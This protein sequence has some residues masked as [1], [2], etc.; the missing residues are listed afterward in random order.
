MIRDQNLESIDVI[1]A[2]IRDSLDA[3]HDKT[4]IN[5]DIL[6][7]TDIVSEQQN[8]IADAILHDHDTKLVFN[9]I[10]AFTNHLEQLKSKNYSLSEAEIQ[11]LF[12][13]ALRP[14]LKSWLNNNISRIVREILEQEIKRVIDRMINQNQ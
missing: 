10:K 8:Y 9:Y 7:L 3:S 6:E 11:D 12:K 13:E 1:L 5:E 14:Y 2:K 4:K